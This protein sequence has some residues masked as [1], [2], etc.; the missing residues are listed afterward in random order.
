[1][2]TVRVLPLGGGWIIDHDGALEPLVFRRGGEA[3]RSAR[4]LARGMADSGDW[5]QV[6]VHDLRGVV[7]GS[8]VLGPD[9]GTP[10]RARRG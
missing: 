9:N 5:A 10:Q 6:V 1:M 2:K 3:E 8:V 7:V 4:R